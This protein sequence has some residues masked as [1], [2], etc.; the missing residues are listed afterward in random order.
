MPKTAL[1]K[2]AAIEQANQLGLLNPNDPDQKYALLSSF[3]LSDLVP[4]LNVHV[5]AALNLQDEFERWVE[6]PQGPSPL[7]IKPW[8]DLQIHLSERIKWL[9]TDKMREVM[10]S[11][12]IVE[13]IVSA[14]LQQLQMMLMPP[15]MAAP[16][17]EPKQ[18]SGGQAMSNSNSLSAAPS[19][20]PSG[21]AMMPNSGPTGMGPS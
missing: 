9:N 8:F 15:P 7:V 10:R 13:Q 2:R 21:A 18:T 11:N 14:H 3:G 17:E 4:S 12:P 1:G 16:G 6:A 20:V 19:S 5:Q